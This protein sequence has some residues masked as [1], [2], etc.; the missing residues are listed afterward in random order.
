MGEHAEGIGIALEVYQI[1]P[2][3][4]AQQ[5]PEFT[6]GALAEECSDGFLA[7]MAEGWI[8]EIVSQTC[9]GHDVSDVIECVG[10]VLAGIPCAQSYG[11]LVGHRL[12]HTGHF[13]RVSET[14]VHKDA[15]RQREYLS[16]ILQATEWRREHKPVVI[17]TEIGADS[18]LARVV[19]VL[20]AKALVA[21][22]ARPLHGLLVVAYHPPVAPPPPVMPPPNPPPKLPPPNP[23][24]KP[25]PRRDDPRMA[26]PAAA[27]ASASGSGAMS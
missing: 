13:H 21:N 27:A 9:R 1:G 11:Y 25:P 23:P 8:P 10:P 18:A 16:L 15:A 7:R 19:E 24:P 20:E 5:R 17:S 22:K 12:A 6:P 26:A 4:F 14:I 3:R 2:F